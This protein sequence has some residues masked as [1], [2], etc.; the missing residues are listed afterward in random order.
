VWGACVATQTVSTSRA[1]CRYFAG[2]TPPRS[3]V[4]LGWGDSQDRVAKQLCRADR[5]PSG[6]PRGPPWSI[7]QENPVNHLRHIL[8]CAIDLLYGRVDAK[9]LSAHNRSLPTNSA[10][11]EPS[12][13]QRGSSDLSMDDARQRSAC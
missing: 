5:D 1:N 7:Q 8:V 11:K 10:V 13:G 2:D 6:P 9:N 12:G 3:P 4:E